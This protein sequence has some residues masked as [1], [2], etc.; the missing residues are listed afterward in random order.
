MV[1]LIRFGLL[2]IL[3]SDLFLNISSF[4]THVEYKI[5]EVS[6]PNSKYKFHSYNHTGKRTLSSLKPARNSFLTRLFN[7]FITSNRNVG[8]KQQWD[9]FYG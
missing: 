3:L 4:S 8:R 2:I 6:Q 5:S 7:G 9:T 1:F